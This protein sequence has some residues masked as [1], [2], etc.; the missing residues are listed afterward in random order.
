[1]PASSPAVGEKQP[2]HEQNQWVQECRRR[3]IHLLIHEHGP[4][5]LHD[6]R[7]LLEKDKRW[8]EAHW[9]GARKGPPDYQQVRNY[10]HRLT[11]DK[12]VD[13]TPNRRAYVSIKKPLPLERPMR[14]RAAE[15]LRLKAEG[16]NGVQIAEELEISRSLAYNLINDPYG[17]NERERK[18]SYCPVCGNKL[19][20]SVDWC[21]KCKQEKVENLL[22]PQDFLA[23]ANRV[24]REQ[25]IEVVFGVTPD[26]VRVIRLG[27][28]RGI[29]EHRLP[30][31]QSW[32]DACE[33][34]GLV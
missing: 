17:D 23:I 14:K 11:G 27:T 1:M 22:P 29:V 16:K 6:V 32:D 20:G 28:R 25:G 9:G 19:D 15:A 2:T 30:S 4:L 7:E 5:T 24:Q 13:L 33:E 8:P 18:K 10:V 3:L 26:C 12:C 21:R 34:L 31:R